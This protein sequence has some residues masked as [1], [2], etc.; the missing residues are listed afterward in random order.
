MD[1]QFT[2]LN[3]IAI[4]NQLRLRDWFIAGANHPSVAD[5][6]NGERI[7]IQDIVLVLFLDEV[8]QELVI[9]FTDI[10]SQTTGVGDQAVGRRFPSLDDKNRDAAHKY[11]SRSQK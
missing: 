7:A 4:D 1:N 10:P 6:L 5:V 9:F 11:A 3:D 2:A 8:I